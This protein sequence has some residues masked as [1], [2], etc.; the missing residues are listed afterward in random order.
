MA[1]REG[2]PACEMPTVTGQPVPG[3]SQ[4]DDR[5]AAMRNQDAINV[6]VR[7]ALCRATSE[8][9]TANGDRD[10]HCQVEDLEAKTGWC[11]PPEERCC[12]VGR[13]RF[14][15]RVDYLL[16]STRSSAVKLFGP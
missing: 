13:V 4:G 15:A 9:I 12:D 14:R 6:L 11:T 1:A 10:R 2:N 5:T 8:V 7:S 16:V 3:S